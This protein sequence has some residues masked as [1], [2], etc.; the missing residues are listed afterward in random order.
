[1]FSS[2]SSFSFLKYLSDAGS[3]IPESCIFGQLLNIVSVLAGLCF[4]SWHKH[5]LDYSQKFNQQCYR[6]IRL[7]RVALCF[8]LICAVGM[9]IVANFQVSQYYKLLYISYNFHILKTPLYTCIKIFP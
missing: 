5:L 2:H 1:M 4:Y 3:K 6:Q 9:S 8:G 7:A